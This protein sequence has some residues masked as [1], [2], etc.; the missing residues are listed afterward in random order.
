MKSV[1]RVARV[2][3]PCSIEGSEAVPSV[4]E[5]RARISRSDPTLDPGQPAFR[6]AVVLLAARHVGQN[7]DRLAR[8]TRVARGEL[9]RFARRLC[10]NG[11]WRGSR[12]HCLWHPDEELGA[13]FWADVEIALGR[14]CRRV[15]EGF[16]EWAPAG[17]WNKSYDFVSPAA[18]SSPSVLYYDRGP[19]P[20]PP[21]AA[22][23][24]ERPP[25]AQPSSPL[26]RPPRESPRGRGVGAEIFPGATWLG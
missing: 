10:D 25:A 11:V 16:T 17:H 20:T 7:V 24:V 15:S 14:M 18:A 8:Y 5:L 4:H 19:E 21:V 9:A 1:L 6:A 12:T 13:F 26:P 3:D 23:P 22:D 2:P